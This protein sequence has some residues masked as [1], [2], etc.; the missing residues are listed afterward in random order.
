[1]E[2]LVILVVFLA[3]L[4]AAVL[5]FGM[6]AGAIIWMGYSFTFP[7]LGL[8]TGVFAAVWLFAYLRAPLHQDMDRWGHKRWDSR[9]PKSEIL[10][11]GYVAGA[12]LAIMWGIAFF[13]NW[14]GTG[15]L[16]D[17][18]TNFFIRSGS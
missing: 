4:A 9:K 7:A 2:L 13:A 11:R 5:L 16:L 18:I 1:M 8:I 17:S 10:F 6:A 3:I 15:G 14:S 12:V